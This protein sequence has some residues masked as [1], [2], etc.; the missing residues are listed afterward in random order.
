MDNNKKVPVIGFYGYSKSGKTTL[1]KQEIIRLS[2]KGVKIGVI[3]NTNETISVESDGKDTQLFRESGAEI[4]SFSTPIE[5]SFCLSGNMPVNEIIDIINKICNI[6]LIVVE[7]ARDPSLPKIRIGNRPLRK[8]TLLTFSGNLQE[9]QK[10][11]DTLL[12]EKGEVDED[13]G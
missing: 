2:K 12:Q 7:G 9:I 13:I 8:N 10:I 11:I 3:K 5:T 6:D 4:T 1:I